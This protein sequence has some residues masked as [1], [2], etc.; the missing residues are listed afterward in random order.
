[1]TPPLQGLFF[2]PSTCSPHLPTRPH[3]SG[4][5]GASSL[6]SD[7]WLR[8]SY[9]TVLFAQA[10]CGGPEDGRQSLGP[11]ALTIITPSLASLS[12]VRLAHHLHSVWNPGAPST[13]GGGH[14]C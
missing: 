11:S 4:A 7:S 8:E 10:P 6:R 12:P 5:G 9:G 14:H 2:S 1:M 3:L 13:Y